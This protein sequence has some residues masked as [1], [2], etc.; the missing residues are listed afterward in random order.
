MGCGRL[1]FA[2]HDRC[3][4]WYVSLLLNLQLLRWLTVKEHFKVGKNKQKKNEAAEAETSSSN[5]MSGKEFEKEL[6]KLQV[7][8]VRL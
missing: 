8:L 3:L 7:E 1:T 6:A 5:K 2:L 4:K